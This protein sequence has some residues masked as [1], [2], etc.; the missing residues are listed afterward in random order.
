M[1]DITP[2]GYDE[3]L[4]RLE[5]A[6]RTYNDVRWRIA[7]LLIEGETRYGEMYADAASRIGLSPDTLKQYVWVARKFPENRRRDT[8]YLTFSHYQE[9]S[10]FDDTGLQERALDLAEGQ[11]WSSREMRTHVSGVIKQAKESLGAKTIDVAASG[12][13]GD[14]DGAVFDATGAARGLGAAGAEDI[15]YEDGSVA[16]RF[17]TALRIINA[18]DGEQMA[19]DLEF[20]RFGNFELLDAAADRL[21]LIR[22][23]LLRCT[24]DH[25][26]AP[27]LPVPEGG[28]QGK[29]GCDEAPGAAPVNAGL[30]NG[31]SQQAAPGQD[32]AGN[33]PGPSGPVSAT[34]SQSARSSHEQASLSADNEAGEDPPPGTS[35]ASPPAG[36]A[37]GDDTQPVAGADGGAEG[38]PSHHPDPSAPDHSRSAARHDAADRRGEGQPSCDSPSPTLSGDDPG[39]IPAFLDRRRGLD[40]GAA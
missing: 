8:V 26:A 10:R 29:H 32:D 22:K 11:M 4:D 2:A 35:P 13:T 1:K 28:G 34:V 19:R 15:D 5:Q 38:V 30:S 24:P 17:L 37:H 12:K 23:Y 3:W 36:H 14:G 39:P 6:A 31:Q 21:R 20:E 27:I 18:G 33:E 25:R 9:A 7:D 40:G 16:A